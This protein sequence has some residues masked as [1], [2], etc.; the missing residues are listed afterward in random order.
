MALFRTSTKITLSYGKLSWQDNWSGK[1]RLYDIA[2]ELYKI[3]SRKKRLVSKEL[4][5]GNWITHFSHLYYVAQLRDFI[6]SSLIW[7]ASPWIPC[8]LIQSLGY[9]RQRVSIRQAQ[10]TR[11]SSLGPSLA[12]L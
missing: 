1:G 9:G 3:A 11:L 4:E 6:W 8:S 12:S 2:P 7:S 5:I 10:L